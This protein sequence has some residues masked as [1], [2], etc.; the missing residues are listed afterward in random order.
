MS[1]STGADRGII[2]SAVL[3]EYQINEWFNLRRPF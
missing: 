2:L 1:G 3:E